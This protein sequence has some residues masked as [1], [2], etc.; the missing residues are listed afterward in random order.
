MRAVM[1]LATLLKWRTYH[2]HDSRHSAAGF[3][4]LVLVKEGRL[5]FVETKA[6]GK[7]PTLEQRMWLAALSAV[8]CAE[9]FVWSPD[10]WGTIT[11]VLRGQTA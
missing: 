11:R 3:P 7:S 2:T 1:A 6:V 4:D 5:L 10:D 9:V 8:P